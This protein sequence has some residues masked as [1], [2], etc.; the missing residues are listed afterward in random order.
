[1]KTS[2]RLTSE[3]YGYHT[4][5]LGYHPSHEQFRKHCRDLNSRSSS[6]ENYPLKKFEDTS[7]HFCGLLCKNGTRIY[8]T[9]SECKYNVCNV[10]LIVNPRRLINPEASYLGI[11]PSDPDDRDQF[12]QSF[13][14]CMRKVDLP[15]FID[16]W[17]LKRLDLCVN[18]L[19][20]KKK[21]PHKLLKLLHKEPVPKGYEK[22]LFEQS[23]AG[24]RRKGIKNK[25]IIKFSNDSVAFVVYDK[26]YQLKK[27]NLA[28]PEEF[29]TKGILRVELQLKKPWLEKYADKRHITDTGDLIATL[30]SESRMWI[31]QYA[32]KLFNGGTHCKLEKMEQELRNTENIRGTVRKRMLKI[33]EHLR[34]S[35]DIQCIMEELE[36]S[37]KQVRT[38][39]QHFKQLNL[40]PVA[41]PD[42]FPIDRL[43]SLVDILQDL[44]DDE[45]ELRL[46]GKRKK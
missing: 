15:E 2:I 5:E 44:E 28:L 19:W 34:D 29:I 31:C 22:N 41:L 37:E 24:K 25:H 7:C 35:S 18:I 10:K 46:D 3:G 38:C 23:D 1:M 27:E 16:E 36:L 6:K 45:T 33:A 21:G 12:E 14:D 30:A 4:L 9:E 20:D 13:T 40:H 39:F 43:P 42:D 26:G 32:E 17:A 11:M 8:L